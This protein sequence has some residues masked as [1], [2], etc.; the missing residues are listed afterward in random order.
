MFLQ[1][2][3]IYLVGMPACG[4]STL[5]IQLAE[6]LNLEFVDTDVEI[7]K[8]S[9]QSIAELIKEEGEGAFR[10][11]ERLIVRNLKEESRIVVAT[12][13]GT[14]SHQNNIEYMLQQGIVIYIK[15]P[16][17]TLLTRLSNAEDVSKRPLLA[18]YATDTSGL[19]SHLQQ[20]LL[21]RAMYYEMAHFTVDGTRKVN[22]SINQI[23]KNLNKMI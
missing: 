13:G 10:L 16:S 18:D 7:E 23:V 15:V 1:K 22:D 2:K 9:N 6:Y 20:T 8:V 12:G 5:G 19:L 11:W 4:K 21:K 3:K 14:P 17:E